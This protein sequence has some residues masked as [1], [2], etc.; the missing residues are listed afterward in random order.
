M[1]TPT[2]LAADV[3]LLRGL[4]S[5]VIACDSGGV[6]PRGTWPG[7]SPVALMPRPIKETTDSSAT[8]W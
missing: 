8:G 3:L 4:E 5:D 7:A 2:T 6:V 1:H